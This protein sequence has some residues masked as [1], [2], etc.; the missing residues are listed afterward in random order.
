MAQMKQ[1]AERV[2]AQFVV[3]DVTRVDLSRSPFT[4]EGE[5]LDP[6]TITCDALIVATGAKPKKLG[7]KGEK[8]PPEGMWGRG[9]T[10]CATCD[11]MF[12]KN[13]DV[14]VI[15][16]GDTAMEEATYLTKMCRKVTIIHRR[17]EFRASRIMLER[18]RKNP[19]IEW[20]VPYHVDEILGDDKGNVRGA[21][22]RHAQS[23]EAREL[24]FKGFFLGIG[25]EPNTSI[26]GKQLQ[27]DENGYI[28]VGI[29]RDGGHA[30]ATATNVAGV[31][32]AGDVADHVYRQAVT[33][34]G[35]GCQAAIDAERYLTHR[36]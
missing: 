23:G 26:F 3:G 31:F 28:Q 5:G 16:G 7:L 2:G 22:I 21:R 32:A 9:V 15:G 13:E 29:G 18:A 11:G 30:G 24:A 34:A 35:T 33:A 1:Q 12:Y 36:P 20:A 19:K 17:D 6:F 14:V 8:E 4:I 10:A 27:L 25:H